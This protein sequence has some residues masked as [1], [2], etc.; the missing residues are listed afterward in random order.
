MVI[1][2]LKSKIRFYQ[3]GS[4]GCEQKFEKIKMQLAK[5][6][7]VFLSL[8][9]EKKSDNTLMGVGVGLEKAGNEMRQSDNELGI[10]SLLL[11][12]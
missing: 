5:V 6:K 3:G 11:I 8:K 7:Q 10:C 2:V 12:T 4:G 9:V 1:G